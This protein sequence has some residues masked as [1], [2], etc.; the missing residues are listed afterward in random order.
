MTMEL[1]ASVYVE[2][3]CGSIDFQ[4]IPST[5]KDLYVV[6]D[7]VTGGGIYCYINGNSSDATNY[8]Y[9]GAESQSNYWGGLY[10]QYYQSSY[11]S[12]GV[13]ISSVGTAKAFRQ[14]WFPRYTDTTTKSSS[15]TGA[16]GGKTWQVRGWNGYS[17]YGNGG[18]AGGKYYTSSAINRLYFFGTSSTSIK[19]GSTISIQVLS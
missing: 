2:T 19:E 7:L 10:G 16:G 8:E 11:S 13:I 14:I 1:A 15:N 6:L 9:T 3:D 4:N 12:M 18:F 17:S 5:G